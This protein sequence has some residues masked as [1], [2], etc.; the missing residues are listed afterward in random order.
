MP[1]ALPSFV[2]PPPKIVPLTRAGRWR[3]AAALIAASVL[4]V[5]QI[6]LADWSRF[7]ASP[8][9]RPWM[10]SACETLGCTLPAWREPSAFVVLNREIQ[11]HPS[12]RQALLVTASFR[13]D[14]AWAQDWPLLELA[15]TDLDGQRIGLRR[16]QPFEYLGGTPS[17]EGLAPGQSATVAL[18]ILDPGNRAVAFEFDFH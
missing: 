5:V 17:R 2:R 18:E 13:N 11:P 3:L 14:A 6:V 8:T 15:L 4:L 1:R 12:N 10:A 7:A 16:F 9:W